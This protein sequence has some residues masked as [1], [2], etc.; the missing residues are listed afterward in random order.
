M[1]FSGLKPNIPVLVLTF[2]LASGSLAVLPRRAFPDHAS[3]MSG[4]GTTTAVVALV[5]ETS[6]ARG[7]GATLACAGCVVGAGG[8]IFAGP[9]AILLALNTPGSALIAM[10][11]ATACFEAAT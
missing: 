8:L 11:C 2:S 10:S 1:P 7:W 9:G 3:A 4:Q 5:P 6:R